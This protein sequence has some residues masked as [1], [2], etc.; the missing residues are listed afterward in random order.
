[1]LARLP[2]SPG[3]ASFAEIVRRHLHF[4]VVSSSN[5]YPALAHLSTNSRQ[6]KVLVWQLHS[7]HRAGENDGNHSLYF[8]RLLFLVTHSAFL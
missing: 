6:N 7:K 8:Y 2:D 3:D 4:N 5:P 1:M